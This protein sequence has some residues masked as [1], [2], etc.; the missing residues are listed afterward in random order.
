MLCGCVLEFFAC[1]SML[2]Y[3]TMPRHRPSGSFW[4]KSL[5][6]CLFFASTFAEHFVVRDV[7][8]TASGPVQ[9]CIACFLMVV[10]DE[11][12]AFA[13]SSGEGNPEI[14]TTK[15]AVS[16]GFHKNRKRFSQAKRLFWFSRHNHKGWG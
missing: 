1:C 11:G 5:V 4:S 16:G 6:F 12:S 3:G 15:K 13:V 10:F 8:A 2:E 9:R 14:A 7:C